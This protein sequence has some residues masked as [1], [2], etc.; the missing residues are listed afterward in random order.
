MVLRKILPNGIK[1]IAVYCIP[2]C[3]V[4]ILNIDVNTFLKN[5]SLLVGLYV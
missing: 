3:P 1:T 4:N 2:K 5:T